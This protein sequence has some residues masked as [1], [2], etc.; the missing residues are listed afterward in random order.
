MNPA[1]LIAVLLLGLC[2]P[3]AARADT[4]LLPQFSLAI[5]DA[6]DNTPAIAISPGNP[7]AFAIPG[8]APSGGT[9]YFLN[10]TLKVFSDFHIRLST[11]SDI[12]F[13]HIGPDGP[14]PLPTPPGRIYV[15][16]PAS[17]R[18][19]KICSVDAD[20]AADGGIEIFGGVGAE[21]VFG[22]TYA[23]IPGSDLTRSIE[24]VFTPSVTPEPQIWAL[25]ITGFFGVG[26]VLRR[27]RTM[28]AA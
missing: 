21:K 28:V 27:R 4:I 2:A 22:L 12:D 18:N 11:F 13:F 15:Y 9:L 24:I 25:M 26:G 7:Y 6:P 17:C 8:D 19:A 14:L 23:S 16:P 10:D 5:F 3:F 20:P 1:A